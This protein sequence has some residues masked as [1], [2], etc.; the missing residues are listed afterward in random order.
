MPSPFAI[1]SN[2]MLASFVV[3]ISNVFFFKPFA[4]LDVRQI[5]NDIND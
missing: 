2:A 1:D 5:A 4:I 3:R